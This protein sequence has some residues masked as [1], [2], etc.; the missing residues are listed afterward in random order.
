M[1]QE[2]PGHVIVSL[3]L[4]KVREDPRTYV[5]LPVLHDRPMLKTRSKGEVLS[6]RAGENAG[7]DKFKSAR[8]RDSPE[9]RL[10]ANPGQWIQSS[11]AR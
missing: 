3:S 1:M 8:L 7:I 9:L 11:H 5:S 2:R 10:A 4:K 6:F